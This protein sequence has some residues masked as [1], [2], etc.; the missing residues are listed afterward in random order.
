MK[1]D[2]IKNRINP[3]NE[4]EEK[5]IE[6]PEWVEGALWGMARSGHPEGMVLNHI[7]AVLGNIEKLE[8]LSVK[9]REDLRL[10][11]LIHDTFKNKV[12]IK[13][14]RVGENNHANIAAHFSE[15]Y[16]K[17]RLIYEVIE[18][19]D[20]AFN[21]WAQG[22][23]NDVWEKAESRLQRLIEIMGNNID[24]YYQFYKCDNLLPGKSQEPVEWFEAQIPSLNLIK[25]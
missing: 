11:A 12:D 9:R 22:V 21:A 17:D 20:E 6:D 23:R 10:I 4:R 8:N 16:T 24:L 19:H 7:V 25:I 14:P 3:E 1:P 13:K 2:E 5:I 15:K 18:L